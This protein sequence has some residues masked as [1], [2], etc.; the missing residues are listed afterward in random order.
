MQDWF[1]D[2]AYFTLFHFFWISRLLLSVKL[3]E[4]LFSKFPFLSLNYDLISVAC[5]QF[6]FK[7]IREK[8]PMA[9]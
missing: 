3:F 6:N 4:C 8:V 2:P 1:C 7:Y 5:A 9:E